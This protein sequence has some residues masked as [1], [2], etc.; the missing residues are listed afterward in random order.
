AAEKIGLESFDS[1]RFRESRLED[2]RKLASLFSVRDHAEKAFSLQSIRSCPERSARRLAD[3]IKVA[4]R[5]V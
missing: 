1:G 3:S 2:W 5:M 4:N